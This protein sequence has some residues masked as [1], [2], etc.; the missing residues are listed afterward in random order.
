MKTSMEEKGPRWQIV[1]IPIAQQ[2]PPTLQKRKIQGPQKAP[3]GPN[4]QQEER[5][6]PNQQIV[7]ITW[8]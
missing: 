1:D 7:G 5:P 2:W 8:W 4:N 6:S 3:T